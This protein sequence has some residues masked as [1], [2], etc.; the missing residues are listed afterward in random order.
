[1]YLKK[2]DNTLRKDKTKEILAMKT[3]LAFWI[4]LC[5][6]ASVWA[7][8]AGPLK[9][10]QMPID[11]VLN[12]LKDPLYKDKSQENVQYNNI[13]EIIN[14]IFNFSLIAQR[15]V[16]RYWKEFSAEEKQ[17]FTDV[18]AD[19]LSR[20]YIQRIQGEYKNESVVYLG[21]QMLSADK[22]LVQTKIVREA[23]DIPVDYYMLFMDN[24]WQIYDVHVEGVS[25]VQN[26]RTQFNKILLKESPAQLIEK[27]K[28]K[29]TTA[30]KGT[31][32]P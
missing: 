13:R 14:H 29:N 6:C 32:V 9:A 3:A 2:A 4:G 30:T 23:I 15:S 22:S 24:S 26:Y 25:L 20:T 19:L 16:G 17:T 31:S 11:S 27:I 18:F 8:T 5:L 10:L 28:N 7:E 1:M 21:E 12:L